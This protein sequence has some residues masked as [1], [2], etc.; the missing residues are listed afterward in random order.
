MEGIKADYSFRGFGDREI[1]SLD[2]EEGK[3][4]NEKDFWKKKSKHV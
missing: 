3:S 4:N 1:E 2:G